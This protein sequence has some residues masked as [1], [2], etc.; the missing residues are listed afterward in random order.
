MQ[1]GNIVQ[2]RKFREDRKDWKN[3]VSRKKYERDRSVWIM[4]SSV[5]VCVENKLGKDGRLKEREWLG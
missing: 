5:K 4:K 3:L 1:G 2:V